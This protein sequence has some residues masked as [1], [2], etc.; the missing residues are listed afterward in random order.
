MRRR[1][2]AAVAVAVVVAVLMGR[3][4]DLCCLCMYRRGHGEGGKMG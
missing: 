2:P 3:R 1:E 4:K